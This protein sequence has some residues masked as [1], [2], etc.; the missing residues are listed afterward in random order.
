MLTCTA[1]CQRYMFM[2]MYVRPKGHLPREQNLT[3]HFQAMC[4]LQDGSPLPRPRPLSL[5]LLLLPPPL[6]RL[7]LLLLLLLLLLL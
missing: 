4:P 6:L 7:T 2:F 3:A 1:C 5:P